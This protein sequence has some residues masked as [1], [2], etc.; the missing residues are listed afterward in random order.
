MGVVAMGFVVWSLYGLIG[1][2][3]GASLNVNW[4][5][6]VVGSIPL[7]IGVAL[8]AVVWTHF[9]SWLVGKKVPFSP[10]SPST[11]SRCSRDSCR[12]RSAWSWCASRGRRAWA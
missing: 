4:M 9:A 2:W 7:A 10:E 5:L 6:V 1:R 8:Q 3:D 11:W 12:A